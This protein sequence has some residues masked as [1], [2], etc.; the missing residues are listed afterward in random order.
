M[1]KTFIKSVGA[2]KELHRDDRT[3]IAWIE[4]GSTGNGHTAHPN[5]DAT[6]SVRGMKKLGYWAKDARTVRSHGYIYNIDRLV[7]TDEL[8]EIARQYCRCGGVHQRPENGHPT[9]A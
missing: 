5:I 4:D 8:D 7:V 3:G 6:G 9:N 2:Y 1:R